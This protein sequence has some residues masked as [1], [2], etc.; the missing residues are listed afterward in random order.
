MADERSSLSADELAKVR[1]FAEV[2]SWLFFEDRRLGLF[3]RCDRI[4]GR[5]SDGK[6]ASVV[7]VESGWELR[8][9]DSPV[10]VGD[11]E[12]ALRVVVGKDFHSDHVVVTP[13]FAGLLFQGA[14]EQTQAGL[15]CYLRYVSAKR[16]AKESRSGDLESHEFLAMI[17]GI[18]TGGPVDAALGMSWLDE[19]LRRSIAGIVLA[20]AAAEAQVNEWVESAG[21]WGQGE[22]QE[23]LVRKM[24][25]LAAKKSVTLDIGAAPFQRLQER[26]EFR[27]ELVHPKAKERELDMAAAPVP[28]LDLSLGA[29]ETCLLVRESLIALAVRLGMA[30]PRFLAYCPAGDFRDIQLW[31]TA[32]VMTGVRE[33]PDFP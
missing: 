22:D 26:V 10:V 19:S 6:A 25:L 28:G 29:R 20:I 15:D 8:L 23:S 33:D 24:K 13:R 1:E 32:V 18:P 27:H 21:G 31:S 7:R 4:E 14:V 30:R 12:Q 5:T 11:F 3:D 16:E 9:G 2:V 17:L